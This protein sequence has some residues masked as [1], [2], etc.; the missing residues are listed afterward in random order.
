MADGIRGEELF[1]NIDNVVKLLNCEKARDIEGSEGIPTMA[2][3][4]CWGNIRKINS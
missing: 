2:I 1:T 4:I 3:V